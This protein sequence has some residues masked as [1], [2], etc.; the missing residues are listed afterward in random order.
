M[1]IILSPE[2][3]LTGDIGDIGDKSIFPGVFA[4]FER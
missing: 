1:E 2:G 3:F 4:F